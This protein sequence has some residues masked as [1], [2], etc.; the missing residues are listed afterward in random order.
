MSLALARSLLLAD[1]VTSRALAEALFLSATEDTS[2]VRALLA[3]GA[4]DHSRL[5]RH[6]EAGEAPFMRQVMPVLPLVRM[7]PPGLCQRLLA[8]PVRH[9]SRTSTVDVAVVDARDPH[10]VEEMGHW[11]EAPVR[12]VRTSIASLDLALEAIGIAPPEEGMR[13]LAPP[14]WLP[15]S[16]PPRP[17]SNTPPHGSRAL[18]AIPSSRADP[19]RTDRGAPFP[20]IPFVLTRKSA[21]PSTE[22]GPFGHLAAGSSSTPPSPAGPRADIASILDEVRAARDRD[23]ILDRVLSG[24]LT[25]ARRAALLAVRRGVLV[26]WTCSPEFAE[27][28]SLRAVRLTSAATAFAAALDRQGTLLVRIPLDAAHAP[29][30]WVMNTPPEAELAIVAVRAEGKPVAVVLADNLIEPAVAPGHLEELARVAGA[31]IAEVMRRRR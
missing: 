30:L 22:R 7:L 12:M 18:D 21:A 10:P 27:R 8:L 5:Q 29:L 13:A 26:G 31:A 1:A 28:A 14:I 16:E 24:A 9:D 2:L 3:T 15:A 25:V 19:A 6:L 23:A 17:P 11:L 20:N 4:I